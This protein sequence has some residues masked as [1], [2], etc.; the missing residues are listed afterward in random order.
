VVSF[1]SR[2]LYRR[3][4]SLGTHW[5]G[6]WVD[7]RAGLDDVEKFLTLPGLELRLHGRPAL[8]RSIHRLHYPGLAVTNRNVLKPVL[9]KVYWIKGRITF[10]LFSVCFVCKQLDVGYN[11]SYVIHTKVAASYSQKYPHSGVCSMRNKH[12]YQIFIFH[13]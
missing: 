7:S 3:G 13:A 9:R 12:K 8:S 6:G 1:T 4:K 2:P 5:I 11:Q 10:S